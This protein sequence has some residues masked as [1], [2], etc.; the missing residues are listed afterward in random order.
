MNQPTQKPP[1]I[2]RWL[3]NIP[4]F[5]AIAENKPKPD[6]IWQRKGVED[7]EALAWT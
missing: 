7:V 6:V 3:D 2:R 5:F 1:I 4:A